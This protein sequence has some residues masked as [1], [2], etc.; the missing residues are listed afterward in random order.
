[1]KTH[2]TND[3]S[4]CLQCLKV[5]DAATGVDHDDVPKVGDITI[6]AY[7]A[8]VGKFDENMSLREISVEELEEINQTNPL[9]YDEIARVVVLIK[10]TNGLL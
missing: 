2:K 9:V 4:I 10:Q 3:N 5:L 1:M 6:C 7:C 8:T